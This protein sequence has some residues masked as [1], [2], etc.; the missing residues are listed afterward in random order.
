VIL[1][2]E[3]WQQQFG[4][5][6]AMVGKTFQVGNQ[7]AEVVGILEPAVE[8]LWFDGSNIERRPEVYVTI[9]QTSPPVRAS[10]YF[11][12]PSAD[13]GRGRQSPRRRRK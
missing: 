1:S 2:H 11:S 13:C 9:R 8:L 12:A 6:A 4:G 10:T 7:R 3:F 5:D